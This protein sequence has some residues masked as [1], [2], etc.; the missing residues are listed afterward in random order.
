MC[1][2]INE[3]DPE[4]IKSLAKRLGLDTMV[5]VEQ[6]CWKKTIKGGHLPPQPATKEEAQ[7]FL[8]CLFSAMQTHYAKENVKVM[9]LHAVVES[10][11]RTIICKTYKLNFDE[12]PNGFQTTY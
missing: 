11:Q 7:E 8:A 5:F 3:G 2:N 6:D 10:A 9:G 12:L 1:D 4:V